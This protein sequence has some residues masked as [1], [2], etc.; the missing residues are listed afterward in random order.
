MGAPV[1]FAFLAGLPRSGST[2]FA[3]LL[4][5]HPDVYASPTSPVCDVMWTARE[6][7]LK[8][9]QAAAFPTFGAA[10]RITRGILNGYYADRSEAVIVDKCWT[11]GTPGNVT[12]LAEALGQRPRIIVMTRPI[13]EMLASFVRLMRKSPGSALEPPQSWRSPDD[14][15]CD[16][17]M[18]P[19]GDIDRALW[20][21][22]HLR[23]TDAADCLEITYERL[24][25]DPHGV[26]ADAWDFL[27]VAPVAPDVEN[28][29]NVTRERDVDVY[30][31]PTLHDI[32]PVVAAT[33]PPASAI[34]SEY[35]LARYGLA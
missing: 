27:N 29:V 11:W 16:W 21:I 22:E 4:N 32:R 28:V 3:S 17:L 20:G 23:S 1:T 35:A 9:D 33:A 8:S 13:P 15:R 19:G 6:T 30:R 2:L 10:S 31:L 24:C 18:R 12:M 7:Y 5:Q 26:M 14:A 25:K 34:L